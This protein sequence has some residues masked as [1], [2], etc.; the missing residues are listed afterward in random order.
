MSKAEH[1]GKSTSLSP[2]EML[3][4]AKQEEEAQQGGK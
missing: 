3:E 2:T 4:K 1:E